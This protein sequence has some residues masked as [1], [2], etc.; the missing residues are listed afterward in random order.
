MKQK[1]EKIKCD[2]CVWGTRVS[3]NKYLCRFPFC[4]KEKGHAKPQKQK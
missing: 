2:S 3:E 4:V 1:K